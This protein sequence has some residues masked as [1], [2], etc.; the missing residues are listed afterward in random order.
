[1]K[2]LVIAALVAASAAAAAPVPQT[3]SDGYT[4]YEL[5][6]PDSHSFRIVYEITATTPGATTYYNPI[7]PGSA[8]SDEH[9][10]DRATG[11]PLAF[12][13]V[14]G[15]T[16]KAGGVTDAQ[17]DNRF[18]AVTLARPVP[19]AGGGGRILIV[20]TYADA[21]S[22]HGD[23]AG[24]VFDRPL[25]IARNAVLLPKGYELTACNVPSQVL[26]QPDGRIL[27]SFWNGSGA[28]APLHLVARP[29]ALPVS[30]MAGKLPERAAQTRNIVYYLDAPETHRFSLTH[31]YT[32]SRPGIAAYVNV[33]RTGSTVADPS[34][35]DLDSGEALPHALV[36]GT[37]I[38]AVEPEAEGITATSEAVVFRFAPVK[39]GES[40]RIRISETY[41]DAD[42]YGVKDGELVW[43]RS[44]GRAANAVVLPAGWA[45]TNSSV[46]ATVSLTDDGRTRLDFLNPRNDEIDVLITAG[47]RAG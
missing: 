18:I 4:R 25:G 9:V 36:H 19:A 41:T 40:R 47:R 46:P 39:P 1:M 21:R 35:R 7:R 14:D 24:I 17:P 8:A 45:L 23:G 16:A 2:G 34:A 12:R 5:L 31:D 44:F 15:A 30:P 32:E 28:P 13:E 11:R 37:A 33:V 3:E 27:V 43:H 42:R 29:A 22:Y 20:K 10:S 38:K 26:Q 6:A